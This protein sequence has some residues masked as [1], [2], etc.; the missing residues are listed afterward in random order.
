[1][2]Y[3]RLPARTW[4]AVFKR[5]SASALLCLA[6]FCLVALLPVLLMSVRSF[7]AE[8]SLTVGHYV[9]LL[10]P[11]WLLLFFRSVVLSCVAT[12]LAGLLGVPLAF[13]L[14]RFTFPGKRAA[15]FLC[16]A[17]LLIPP[18]IQTLSWLYLYGNRGIF[19]GWLQFAGLAAPQ[20]ALSS[21]AGVILILAFS[22]FP[23]ITL[24]TMAG[25]TR[26]DRYLEESAG[27]VHS[28]WTVL[29]T[30]TLPLVSPYIFAGF[31]IVFIFS[32]FNYGVPSLLRVPTYPIEIFTR[33]SAFYDEA[34]AAA[35]SMPAVLLVAGAYLCLRIWFQKRQF[36]MR[37]PGLRPV[38]P[39]VVGGRTKILMAGW[40]TLILTVGVLLPVGS[41]FLQAG[42]LASFTLAAGGSL[43]EFRTTLL[44]SA[45]SASCITIFA[46]CLA[47]VMETLS[48]GRQA[49]A[50]FLAFLP[51]AFPATT[52]GIGLIYLWNSRMTGFL[53]T[54]TAML[55]LAMTAR[56]LPLA[57]HIIRSSLKQV[58]PG[59]LEAASFGRTSRLQRWLFIDFPL[60]R[61]GLAACWILAFVFCT[62]ELGTTLLVIPPGSGT[63]SLKI[64]NLL[65]YGA[66]PLV[67]ALALLLL[68][69]NFTVFLGLAKIPLEI[70]GRGPLCRN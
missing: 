63:V 21:T 12:F 64:Y 17:P 70:F 27:F 41:L 40:I 32:F 24:L 31:L 18:H 20:N 33:F 16:L 49:L 47:R 15:A 39:V 35:M 4:H 50:E 65:H 11:R 59:L 68:G 46:F 36:A 26:I 19:H 22:Y 3:S 13:F 66:G 2:M 10:Q 45:G 56:F 69:I 53:Y 52:L 57:I 1:M 6:F 9:F 67:A 23:L 34:G 60:A 37:L 42:S 55:L 14:A 48:G 58:H 38:T 44:I 29:R 5:S 28:P 25:L 7:F 30:I 62:G 8:G 54:S 43:R 51:F 61:R